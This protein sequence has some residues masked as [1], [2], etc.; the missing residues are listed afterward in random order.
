MAPDRQRAP[1]RIVVCADD[2]GFTP[3]ISRGIRELLAARRISATSAMTGSEFW[4]A[5]AP[6]LRAV[7]GDAD[8]GLHVTLTD[9]KPLGTMRAFAPTGRF[10]SLAAVLRAGVMRTLPLDEIEAELE[11]QVAA[12][13]EHYGRPPAH[14]DGHHHMHQLPGVRDIVVGIAARLGQ[15]RIWVRSCGERP[16]LVLRRGVGTAK[17][18]IIG[19]FGPAVA[20]HARAAGVP[21]NNG[22]SGAYDFASE[23]RPQAELFARFVEAAKDNALVMCHPGY[24]D[25]ALVARDIMTTAREAELAFLLSDD[26]PRLLAERGFE[27]GPLRRTVPSRSGGGGAVER[28]GTDPA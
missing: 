15:G 3:G 19:A 18:L 13:V 10:P 21:I 17:A 16:G 8:I 12:F 24:A 4:P 26:W 27:L 22:F 20:R 14:I 7:S 6:A 9:Q 11:R 2:Y 25:E 23:T 28:I 5:E 1:V